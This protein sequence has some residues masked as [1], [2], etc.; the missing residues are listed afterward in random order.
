MLTINGVFYRTQDLWKSGIKTTAAATA[1]DKV[2]SSVAIN[3]KSSL[4]VVG[5]PEQGSKV[6]P[7]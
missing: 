4:A 6:I 5:A 1:D 2:G 7:M 3:S